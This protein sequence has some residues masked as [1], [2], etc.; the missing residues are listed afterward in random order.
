M[1][2]DPRKLR[3]N[4]E[5]SGDVERHV[6]SQLKHFDEQKRGGGEKISNI[7]KLFD[8]SEDYNRLE[9]EYGSSKPQGNDS[10]QQSRPYSTTQ[11]KLPSAQEHTQFL[12]KQKQ[13]LMA[14]E[15]NNNSEF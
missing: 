7:N 9:D 1:T 14:A 4:R 8:G 13:Q 15:A 2:A 12:Q 5:N 3:S 6:K 10:I 11:R